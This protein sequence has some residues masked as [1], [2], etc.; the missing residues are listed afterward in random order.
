MDKKVVLLFGDNVE[1]VKMAEG[2]KDKTIIKIG[3]CEKEEDKKTF[4]KHYDIVC[5]NNTD[6]IEL[7]NF[8]KEKF[9]FSIF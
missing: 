5:A 1:D 7:N 8:L 3:F 2:L 4:K 9:Q 6:F